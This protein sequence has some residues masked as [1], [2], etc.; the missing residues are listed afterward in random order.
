MQEENKFSYRSLN[1]SKEKEWHFA[2]GLNDITTAGNYAVRLYHDDLEAIGISTAECDTEHYVVAHLVVIESAATGKQQKMRTVGQTLMF[3]TCTNQSMKII[4]RICV[5][6]PDGVVWHPW[7]DSKAGTDYLPTAQE[8]NTTVGH[9]DNKFVYKGTDDVD[10]VSGG[11]FDTTVNDITLNLKK[12]GDTTGLGSARH[13]IAAATEAMAGVMSAEDKKKLNNAEVV[14]KVEWGVNSNI[15]DYTSSGVYYI[16]GKRSMSDDG[17]PIDTYPHFTAR[18]L[19][20]G[21]T[22]NSNSIT[23][24]LSLN[25][26]GKSN[27]FMRNCVLGDTTVWGKW[28]I[29]QQNTNVGRV[30]SLDNFTAGGVY[31]G[32]YTGGISHET[33]V[34]TVINNEAA[35]TAAGSVRC[36]SQFKYALDLHSNYSYKTRTGRGTEEIEWGDWVD[37]GAP[38]TVN[39]QDGAVTEQKLSSD[40]KEKIE[41]VK[42]LEENSVKDKNALLNGDTIVGMAREVYSRQGK[43]D[44]ATFLKRT[45]AGGTSISDGVATL[46]QIG[47]NIIINKISNKPFASGTTNCISGT[48]TNIVLAGGAGS[49]SFTGY[50]TADNYEMSSHIYYVSAFV[51]A[52]GSGTLNFS[53]TNSSGV[54]DG[55]FTVQ[56]PLNNGWEYVSCRYKS[57]SSSAPYYR[58]CSFGCPNVDCDIT[59]QIHSVLYIDLTEM[60]GSGYEPSKDV[61][62]RLFS[63]IGVLQ[64][65]VVVAKPTG[66]KSIGYNQWNT[67]DAFECKSISDG[68]II[69]NS[70]TTVAIIE[71][72]PCKT[73]AGENNGYIIGYGEG[74]DWTDEGIDVYLTPLNPLE[75]NG[76][77]YLQ[78][79]EKDEVYGTYIPKI[80][81]YM[82]VVTPT[83]DKFCANF[84]W[85][86]DRSATDYEPYV[87][88]FVELPVIPEISEWGLAGMSVSGT[89][90]QDIIDLEKNCYT[91][92]IGCID[93]GSKVGGIVGNIYHISVPTA[94][95]GKMGVIPNL[96]CANYKTVL[97]N[98]MDTLGVNTISINDNSSTVTI[99]DSSCTTADE[100]AAKLNGVMLYYELAEPEEYQIVTKAASNYIGS[101]YGIEEF[102]GSSVPLVANILFYL[103]SLVS[104]TRNFLDRLMAGFGV[105]D[106]TVVAD[107]IIAAVQSHDAADKEAVTE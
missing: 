49:L 84:H 95:K 16:T 22:E 80:K 103:R 17:L 9:L 19:V 25:A 37:L 102:T 82:L 7:V 86:G 10:I 33:F 47:G 55:S 104:E 32:I 83:T 15:N 60:F 57:V 105:S 74:D 13:T 89:P 54:G 5:L 69:D 44:T 94:S 3:T 81:G 85:S 53:Y 4:T 52:Q 46:K 42:L 101:D 36:I 2:R 99:Y 100:Y 28:S 76:D 11:Y 93:L 12:W 8:L 14:A 106:V 91:K 66:L 40:V 92:S 63:T 87:E 29:L 38:G 31:S 23:Q 34:L 30:A 41:K 61:C 67:N 62:D 58:A 68:I 24:I 39:I 107:R 71:C 75:T 48:V 51:K 26:S 77:L 6:T 45:T 70:S 21:S 64:G 35:A 20:V 97:R 79:L 59:A 88:S 1:Q 18:L 78:K 72:I 50:Q 90:V 73:G 27:L 56:V 65:G 43:I 96:L 98:G